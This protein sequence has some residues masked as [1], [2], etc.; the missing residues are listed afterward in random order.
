MYSVWLSVVAALTIQFARTI[1]LALT[2]SDF[3]NRPVDRYIAPTVNVAIPD[4]YD[5]W[6]PV[7]MRW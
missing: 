6:T 3:L 1:S 5:K 4:E 2:I 7:I